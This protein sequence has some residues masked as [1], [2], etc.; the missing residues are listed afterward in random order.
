MMKE[1]AAKLGFR[2]GQSSPYYPQSNGQVE[3]VNKVIK[4]MLQRTVDKHRTN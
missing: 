1:L 3:V 2:H 4:T